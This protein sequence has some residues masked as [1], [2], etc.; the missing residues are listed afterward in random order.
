MHTSP[1]VFPYRAVLHHSDGSVEVIDPL[2][3]P[4]P[5]HVTDSATLSIGST[6]GIWRVATLEDERDHVLTADEFENQPSYRLATV[7]LRQRT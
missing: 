6:T 5:V 1:L 3:L 7:H 4:V 2:M